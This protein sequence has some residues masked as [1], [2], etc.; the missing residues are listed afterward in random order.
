MKRSEIAQIAVK[1]CP[2]C[3]GMFADF[4]GPTHPYIDASPACWKIYGDVLAKE[5]NN[6][7]YFK[8]HRLTVDA[9]S[10]QHPGSPGARSSQS[11]NV[12]LVAL[13]LILEQ[14][15]KSEFVTKIIGKLIQ[16]RDRKFDWLSPPKYMGEINVLHM[17]QADTAEEH[18]SRVREW[19]L[20]AFNSWKEHHNIIKMLANLA[21]S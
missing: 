6:P 7:E 21:L 11:V 3:G 19:G 10:V 9:Y 1:H 12:H 8:A 17:A 14:Q 15:L 16:L 4:D 2:G 13:Y 20:S 18:I 5:F